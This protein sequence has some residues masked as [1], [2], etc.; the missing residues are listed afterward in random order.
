MESVT[1]LSEKYIREL[2][3]SS[4]KNILSENEKKHHI[5]INESTCLLGPKSVLDS[6]GLVTLLVD[7]EQ[8]LE[9]KSKLSLSLA[10][11]RALSQKRSPFRSVQSLS[12]YISNLLKGAP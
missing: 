6:L 4:I 10:D 1:N 2:V 11:E 5:K 3:I 12:D 8:C 9:E 7:L